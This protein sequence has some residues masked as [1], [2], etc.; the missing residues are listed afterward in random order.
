M[1]EEKIAAEGL[2]VGA[3]LRIPYTIVTEAV[4]QGLNMLGYKDV[5][6]AH[7]S[8][9]QPL[10]ERPEGMRTTDLATWAQ[11]TKPSIIY[12]VD[13]LEAHT[14]V[15]RI[16]DPR[17]GRAQRVRLTAQGW[18]VVRAAREISRQ[19]EADWQARLGMEQLQQLKQILR[20]LI[21]S[22][23]ADK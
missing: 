7:F 19:V 1:A 13:H 5:R 20:E 18:N 21:A 10:A 11:I 3:L 6:A 16:A 2:L 23:N 14:Y 12:L 22:F 4:E 17:D 8:V 15:E 9:L